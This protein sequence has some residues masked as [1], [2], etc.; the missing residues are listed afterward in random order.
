MTRTPVFELHIRPMFRLID[1]DHMLQRNFD[2]ADFE[3]V[4]EQASEILDRLR[5]SSP[6]PT[7][8]TGGPWPEEWITLFERWTEEFHRLDQNTGS[9]YLL[10]KIPG[11][12]QLS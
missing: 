3:T 1:D 7:Q 12:F 5:S 6:M 2:L 9:G 11:R 4:K 8:A 10:E